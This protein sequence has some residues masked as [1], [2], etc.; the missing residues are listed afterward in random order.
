M[1]G[2]AGLDPVPCQW[3]AAGYEGAI[4]SGR[5]ICGTLFGGTVFLGYLHGKDAS[6]APEFEDAA[7]KAAISSV[8][9]LFRGFLERFNDTDCQR[10]TGCDWS[11]KEDRERYM[12]D[13]LWKH[14]C[15]RFFEYVLEYCTQQK[16]T[17]NVAV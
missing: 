5:T 13:E 16:R 1:R 2:V 11:K 6:Q 12:R 15:S 14:I 10:L 3:A 4:V 17:L 8:N 9:G 7:R